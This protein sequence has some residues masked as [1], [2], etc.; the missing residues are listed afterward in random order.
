M[1]QETDKIISEA[2]VAPMRGMMVQFFSMIYIPFSVHMKHFHSHYTTPWKHNILCEWKSGEQFAA[3]NEG[4]W[5]INYKF[6]DPLC[7]CVCVYLQHCKCILLCMSFF[8]SW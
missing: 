5:V 3:W 1:E 6:I 2:C 4:T 8:I 7:V